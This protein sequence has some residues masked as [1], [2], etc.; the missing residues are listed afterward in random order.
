MLGDVSMCS[1][2][3]NEL[4]YQKVPSQSFANSSTTTEASEWE[5]VFDPQ[6]HCVCSWQG[7]VIATFHKQET[8]YSN[9]HPT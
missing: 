1:C 9:N 3:W 8:A 6:C 7:L 5:W 2:N 4:Y